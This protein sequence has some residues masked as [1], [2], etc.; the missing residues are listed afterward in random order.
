MKKILSLLLLMLASCVM[1]AQ[2]NNS[3]LNVKYLKLIEN[4]TEASRARR[5]DRNGDKCALIKIQ[6]PNMGMT[7]R[8]SLEF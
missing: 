1:S 3:R 8:N 5:T 4:D 7:E 2:E 6:T